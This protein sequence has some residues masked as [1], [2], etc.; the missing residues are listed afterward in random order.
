MEFRMG[1][2]PLDN[3]AVARVMLHSLN[4]CGRALNEGLLESKPLMPLEDWEKLRLGVGHILGNDLY[5]MW[6][7]IVQRHPEFLSEIDDFGG[8]RS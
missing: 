8:R 7:V 4:E 5:D 3:P 1:D 2:V 6:S